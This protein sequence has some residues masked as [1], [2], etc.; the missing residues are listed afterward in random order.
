MTQEISLRDDP[1]AAK[2]LAAGGIEYHCEVEGLDEEGFTF[3]FEDEY[4]N[5]RQAWLERSDLSPGNLERLDFGAQFK[6]RVTPIELPHP[7][8]A[9]DSITAIEVDSVIAFLDQG[10]LTQAEIDEALREARSRRA[11]R[12]QLQFA[13]QNDPR[14]PLEAAEYPF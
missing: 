2:K 14:S 1:F 6:W 5:L 10:T 8:A 3:R 11:A 4:G 13:L 12:W 7:C 9:K